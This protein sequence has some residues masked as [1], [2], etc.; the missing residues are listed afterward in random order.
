MA[1][2]HQIFPESQ[3]VANY[4][5]FFACTAHDLEPAQEALSKLRE[6]ETFYT[7]LWGSQERLA[8]YRRWADPQLARGQEQRLIW[9]YKT[10]VLDAILS[11]NGQ[12]VLSIGNEWGD[13][14][15]LW[16]LKTGELI[17]SMGGSDFMARSAAVNTEKRYL[18]L[19]GRDR[20][21]V[22]QIQLWSLDTAQIEDTIPCEAKQDLLSLVFSPDGK[23]LASADHGNKAMIWNLQERNRSLTLEHPE[24]VWQVAFSPD[25]RQLATVAGT[26]TAYFWDADSGQKLDTLNCTAAWGKNLRYSPSGRFLTLPQD[27]NVVLWDLL[28]KQNQ[29]TISLMPARPA[30]VVI[31]HDG[32][33]IATSDTRLQIKIWDAAGGTALKTFA[34]HFGPIRSLAFSLDDKQV[35]SGSDDSTIRFWDISGLR[36]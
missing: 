9:A 21:G 14:I 20:S 35:I 19:G 28:A 11:P 33:L 10:A 32:K 3:W 8:M 30:S 16:D 12:Q 1:R 4:R 23:L 36:Q 31:S 13:S 34:G 27:Q 29:A 15:K 5:S 18:A 2:L 17:G 22:S 7:N 6:R 24:H 25:G 26:K